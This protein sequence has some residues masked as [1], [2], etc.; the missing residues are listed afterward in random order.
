MLAPLERFADLADKTIEP[1]PVRWLTGAIENNWSLALTKLN[2]LR[3]AEAVARVALRRDPAN[4]IFNETLAFA[5][6]RPDRVVATYQAALEQ[7]PT[8]FT[9]ANNMG[10]LLAASRQVA[11]ARAMATARLDAAPT[12][13]SSVQGLDRN[14]L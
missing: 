10:V 3:E 9:A 12:D 5:Q 7:D 1:Q 14:Q 13:E 2:R 6:Q 4:P 11:T 8:L